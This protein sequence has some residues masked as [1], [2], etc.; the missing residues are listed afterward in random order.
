MYEPST[1]LPEPPT[2]LLLR[3]FGLVSALASGLALAGGAGG[4]GAPAWPAWG[5]VPAIPLAALALGRPET[6]LPLY[7]GWNR[8]A[9]LVLRGARFALSG[10]C[11]SIV[12]AASLGGSRFAWEPERSGASGWKPKR[13]PDPSTYGSRSLAT[14]DDERAGWIRGL[15]A[16]ARS[17]ESEWALALVPFL[18]L[19]R[20][21]RLREAGSL[22]ERIYTL[23]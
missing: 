13:G 5:A 17:T 19:L 8:A 15:V 18:A 14:G 6:L 22:D 21:L 9:R 23:F 1:A 7:E 4:L 3:S 16:W 10:I 20:T 11:F 2:R 12:T